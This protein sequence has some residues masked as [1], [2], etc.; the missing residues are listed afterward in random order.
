MNKSILLYKELLKFSSHIRT[1]YLKN[2]PVF[3][4]QL[5]FEE[6]NEK[7]YLKMYEEVE[8]NKHIK[9][10]PDLYNEI[11]W[12]SDLYKK[13][14]SFYLNPRNK[15]HKGYDVQLWIQFENA[16][17]NFLNSIWITTLRAD[18]KNRKLPDLMVL[19]KTRNIKAYIELK[20]HNAPFMLSWKLI[21][22]EPYEGSITLDVDKVRK[23]LVEI[24]S[25][26]ERPVF[27]VHRVDFPDLKWIFFNTDEQINTYL[28]SEWLEL[29]ERKWR[30]WDY[31]ITQKVGYTEKFYPPL[32]EMW[33]LDELVNFLKR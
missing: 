18:L 1:D 7:C 33:D 3:D 14:R 16:F 17:I 31:K 25:E 9:K 15:S 6:I 28:N 24:H 29:F 4:N 19:D 12:L 13:A 2:V 21:N 30:E 22:R 5:L 11:D 20:Y 8:D 26:L 10:T 23:Q 32:H 27:Y